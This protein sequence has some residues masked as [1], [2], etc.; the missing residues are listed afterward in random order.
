MGRTNFEAADLVTLDAWSAG[1][2]AEMD[3][4]MNE[5]LDPSEWGAATTS[6]YAPT[7]PVVFPSE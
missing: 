6:A 4:A 5:P 1:Y 7:L 3:A 2:A